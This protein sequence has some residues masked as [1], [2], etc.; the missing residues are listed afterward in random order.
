MYVIDLHKIY[1]SLNSTSMKIPAPKPFRPIA[2]PFRHTIFRLG[3]R[4]DVNELKFEIKLIVIVDDIL[5]LLVLK[6]THIDIF[7]FRNDL[8]VQVVKELSFRNHMALM[9]WVFAKNSNRLELEVGDFREFLDP[10]KCHVAFFE[11]EV[12]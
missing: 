3:N 6:S 4:D 7:T 12:A 1:F 5:Q 11:V 2:Y 8:V 10:V 9:P